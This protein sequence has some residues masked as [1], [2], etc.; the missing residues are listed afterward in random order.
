M[1]QLL[2]LTGYMPNPNSTVMGRAL[3]RPPV[4]KFL[5]SNWEAV[6]AVGVA[7]VEHRAGHALRL[8]AQQ[9]DAAIALLADG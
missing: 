9:R 6:T 3:F 4:Y 2:N 5:C 1:S 8:G 7:D